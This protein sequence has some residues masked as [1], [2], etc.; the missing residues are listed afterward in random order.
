M[1]NTN[2]VSNDLTMIIDTIIDNAMT[3]GSRLLEV[4]NVF[5]IEE[6]LSSNYS[7]IILKHMQAFAV[8]NYV[9]YNFLVNHTS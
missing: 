8:H 3:D 5:I 4:I 1:G 7:L 6:S 2:P 9:M